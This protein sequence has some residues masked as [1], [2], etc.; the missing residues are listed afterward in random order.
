MT[1]FHAGGFAVG[2]EQY[3]WYL[4]RVLLL[5]YDADQ[6]AFIGT[7]ELARDRALE[8]WEEN[9]DR[10]LPQPPAPKFAEQSRISSSIIRRRWRF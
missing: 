5:P 2:R 7:Q 3:N 9:R 10:S 4:K 8:A 1:S 6:V